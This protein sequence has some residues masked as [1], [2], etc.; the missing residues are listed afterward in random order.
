MVSRSKSW[1]VT[2]RSWDFYLES[3]D[4]PHPDNR[5][6]PGPGGRI[7][8]SWRPN[9]LAAHRGLVEHTKT[10]LRKMGFPLVLT[11]T[12]GIATN[13]HQCGTCVAGADPG[14]SVLDGLCRTHDVEN[15]LVVDSS[16]F[17]SSAAMNPAL[18][19]A[20]QALRVA[21]EGDVLR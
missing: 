18:T 13:S 16:F 15:L 9:N 1:A 19:I 17:P 6:M 12:M 5:V 2:A 14:S 20:A 3:E 4:L 11:E 8:V 21:H 10:A 7:E